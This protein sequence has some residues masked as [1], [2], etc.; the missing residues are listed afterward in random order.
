VTLSVRVRRRAELDIDEAYAW[1]ES[2]AEVWV[3]NIRPA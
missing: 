2:R 3:L 1:Y